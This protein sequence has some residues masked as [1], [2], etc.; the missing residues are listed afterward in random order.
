MITA[1]PANIVTYYINNF[2]GEKIGIIGRIMEEGMV[3]GPAVNLS[4]SPVEHFV[5]LPWGENG[6]DGKD[7]V[8]EFWRLAG[9]ARV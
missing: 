9:R 7:F 1:A 6:L 2:T 8:P 5:P 3:Y 4:Q